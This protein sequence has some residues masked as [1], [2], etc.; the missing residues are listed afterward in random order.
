MYKRQPYDSALHDQ[1]RSGGGSLA[2]YFTKAVGYQKCKSCNQILSLDNFNISRQSYCK[3]CRSLI[4]S[5]YYKNNKASIIH[6]V[7]LRYA[8]V[9]LATPKWA[10][11]EKIKEIY[12]KCP[13]G[14]HV[15]H[16]VPLQGVLVSG[17]HVENNLQYLTAE[18]NLKKGNKW[19]VS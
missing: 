12:A 17:L 6:N 4:F 8:H 15:D 19:E 9:E 5:E 11:I 16:I 3:A 2:Y 14:Y 1:H 13:T 7:T 18:Q 10:N